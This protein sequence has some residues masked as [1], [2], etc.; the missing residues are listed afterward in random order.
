MRKYH[1]NQVFDYNCRYGGIDDTS[2]RKRV[3]LDGLTEFGQ[4]ALEFLKNAIEKFYPDCK[5]IQT[6]NENDEA[7]KY[8]EILED[9][10]IHSIP[11][12]ESRDLILN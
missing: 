2:G 10:M 7:G 11:I 4:K 6:T 8:E 9:G 5:P 3:K 12:S 1:P